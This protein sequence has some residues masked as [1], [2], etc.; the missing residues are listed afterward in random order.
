VVSSLFLL[1]RRQAGFTLL[2][3]LLSVSLISIAVGISLPVYQG[4]QW[5]T[6]LEVNT[7]SVAEAFRRAQT[8]SRAS[9]GDSQWGVKILPGT[10]VVL[11]KG[12]L[13]SS[14]DAAYDETIPITSPV[15]LTIGGAMS[16]G[17]ETVFTKV[18]GIPSNTGTVTLTFPRGNDVRTVTLNA[19]GMVSY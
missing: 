5:R 16:P 12:S 11:F 17:N 7:Q 10:G 13:Y 19:A 3:A 1:L 2:E 8:F 4:F 9:Y 14:R 18:T 15:T 6:D